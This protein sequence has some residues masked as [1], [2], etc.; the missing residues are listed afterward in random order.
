LGANGMPIPEQEIRRLFDKLA[1]QLRERGAA[2]VVDQVIDEIPQGKQIIYTT[3]RRR[4]EARQ[5]Y[6]P[7][8]DEAI[9]DRGGRREYAQTLE[10]SSAE[11]LDLLLQGLERAIIDA[12]AIDSELVRN[13]PECQLRPRAGRGERPHISCRCSHA[14]HPRARRPKSTHRR[15]ARVNRRVRCRQQPTN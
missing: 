9:T 10:Y 14:Q 5:L 3:V 13:Y 4:T 1:T 8:G 12:G 2:A 15:V 11:R 6:R 7:E